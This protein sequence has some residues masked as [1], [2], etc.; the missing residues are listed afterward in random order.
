[1][2]AEKWKISNL[3]VM[4]EQKELIDH[5]LVYHDALLL[6]CMVLS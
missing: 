6:R 4:Y 5:S 2:S 3:E 1:M